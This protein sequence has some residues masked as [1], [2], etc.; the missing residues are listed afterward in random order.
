MPEIVP[1]ALSI[2]NP[3]GRAGNTVKLSTLPVIMAVS[4][5]IAVPITPAIDN[6]LYVRFDGAT[7]VGVTDIVIIAVPGPALLVAVTVYSVE[8]LSARGVPDI[9]PVSVSNKSPVGNTGD[10][11]QDN[12]VPITEGESGNIAV[13]T[14]PEMVAG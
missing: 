7:T 12:T 3:A 2:I 4:G 14:T 10:I 11:D 8:G 5:L 13:L 1:V 6:V 9:V